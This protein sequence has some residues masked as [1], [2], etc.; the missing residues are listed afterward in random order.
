MLRQARLYHVCSAVSFIGFLPAQSGVGGLTFN[1]IFL[2]ASRQCALGL[3]GNVPAFHAPTQSMGTF[4]CRE[5]VGQ[6]GGIS[7]C[8]PRLSFEIWIC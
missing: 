7:A 4:S 6:Q 2:F 1:N 5:Y 8:G 3:Q